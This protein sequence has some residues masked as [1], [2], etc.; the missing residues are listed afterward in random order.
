MIEGATEGRPAGVDDEDLYR[1]ERLLDLAG[2]RGEPVEVGGVGDEGRRTPADLRHCFFQLLLRAT[3]DRDPRS[4][5]RQRR[6]DR[7]PDP[8]AGAHHQRDA[9]LY[10]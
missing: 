9:A 2:K 1:A 4:F 10:P 3:G 7:P 5:A 8:A 6:R